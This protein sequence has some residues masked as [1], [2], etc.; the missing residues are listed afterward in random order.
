MLSRSERT[1]SYYTSFTRHVT[2]IWA[3]NNR[4][5]REMNSTGR[6]RAHARHFWNS[7]FCVFRRNNIFLDDTFILYNSIELHFSCIS[8]LLYLLFNLLVRCRLELL[9]EPLINKL[10]CSELLQ[11]EAT[12]SCRQGQYLPYSPSLKFSSMWVGLLHYWRE[13]MRGCIVYFA[14]VKVLWSTSIRN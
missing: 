1:A 2:A 9:A 7:C 14:L 11:Y 4:S 8:L 10:N 6:Q 13:L 3:K 12:I 5:K